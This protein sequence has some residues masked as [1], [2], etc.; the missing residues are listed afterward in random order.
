MSYE[1]LKIAGLITDNIQPENITKIAGGLNSNIQLVE[2]NNSKYIIKEYP[3]V[4]IVWPRL[5]TEFNFLKLMSEAK[6]RNVPKAIKKIADF[7]IGI[8]SYIEGEPIIE[9]TDFNVTASAAFIIEINNKMKRFS[10]KI[11]SASDYYSDYEGLVASIERRI[12]SLK[13][14]IHS[15]SQA[16]SQTVNEIDLIFQKTA[17]QDSSFCK[18]FQDDILKVGEV[19]SP[20]DFGFHNMLQSGE[21]LKFLDFEYAG[22]D[23][24]LKLLCDFYC[25]PRIP[26][27]GVQFKEFVNIINENLVHVDEL[28]NSA[29]KLLPLFRLKWACIILNQINKLEQ[30]SHL[31]NKQ[32]EK[33]QA[34]LSQ[35]CEV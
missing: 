29:I 5:E 16:Y 2:V 6:I 21:S 4:D 31:K 13:K 15:D 22:T 33:A 1:L 28:Y 12:M 32:I 27:S 19:I 20:S 30:D 17:K 35:N 10:G 8:Y 25:Q 7:N 18:E 9:A 14:Y 23:N 24:V 11:G 3:A 26:I 34:Y